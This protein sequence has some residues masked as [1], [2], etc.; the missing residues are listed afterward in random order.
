MNGAVYD[1][2]KRLRASY[3]VM[4]DVN[5]QLFTEDVLDELLLSMAGK[6]EEMDTAQAN[7]ILSSLDLLDKRS[8][9]LCLCLAAKN[10]G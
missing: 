6:D 9:I 5:H 7:K 10:S 2:K 1:R 3:M 8:C 4:Q